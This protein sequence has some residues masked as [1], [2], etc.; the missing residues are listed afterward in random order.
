MIL[1]SSLLEETG[2]APGILHRERAVRAP[3][4]LIVE[5]CFFRGGAIKPRR[6]RYVN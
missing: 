5:R 4:P 2:Q 3:S 1:A 6:S